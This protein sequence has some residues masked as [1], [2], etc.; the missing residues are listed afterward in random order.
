MNSR[1]EIREIIAGLVENARREIKV[2]TPSLDPYYFNT[3][4]MEQSL[5]GFALIHAE[6]R[7]KILIEHVPALLSQAR[8]LGLLR[9]LDVRLDIRRVNDH[10]IGQR[11]FFVIADTRTYYYQNDYESLS[12]ITEIDAP[13]KVA[14]LAQRFEEMWERS[15]R[16]GD[17][18]TIGL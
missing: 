15:K 9:R 11:E 2:F 10:D 5:I 18:Q 8:L 7:A 1:E 14:Q 12:G 3:R 17:L 6:S 13:R 4:A 16:I